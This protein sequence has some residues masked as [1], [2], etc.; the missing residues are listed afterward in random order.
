MLRLD[1]TAIAVRDL[2]EALDRYSR[3][4]GVGPSERA[5]V[6]NQGVEIAFLPLGDA[7]L[8]LICPLD[9][10]SGVGRFLEKNGEALHHI[11]VAVLNLRA[12]LKRLSRERIELIDSEPRPGVHGPIAFVHPRG[13][14][15][16]LLELVEISN[17][18]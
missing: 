16:V 5:I 2:D 14:G 10:N 9:N 17:E 4:Y 3:I 1:H 7:S 12:E 13:T 15:G 8:E 11:G 18:P 6:R